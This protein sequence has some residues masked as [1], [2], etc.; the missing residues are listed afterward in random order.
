MSELIDIFTSHKS[1]RSFTEQPVDEAVLDRIIS[2][3]Y[4]AP[5]SEK[6]AAGFCC[7]YP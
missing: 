6:L 2:T 1:E 5:T 7:H 3:A 4:R